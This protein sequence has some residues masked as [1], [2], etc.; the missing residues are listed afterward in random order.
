MLFQMFLE[1]LILWEL[2]LGGYLGSSEPNPC[3]GA[4]P[5]SLR[6]ENKNTE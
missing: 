1:I 5:N 3:A 2:F 6:E 4:L